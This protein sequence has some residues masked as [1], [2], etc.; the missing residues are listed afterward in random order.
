MERI[1]ESFSGLDREAYDYANQALEQ[2]E[3]VVLSA[4]GSLEGA[5]GYLLTLISSGVTI[6]DSIEA[7][8]RARCETDS[9]ALIYAGPTSKATVDDFCSGDTGSASTSAV[10]FADPSGDWNITINFT[11]DIM[12]TAAPAVIE[13]DDAYNNEWV[14]IVFDG[15]P[16]DPYAWDLVPV[17]ITATGGSIKEMR[18]YSAS[19][20]WDPASR[21]PL[22]TI[23]TPGATV[24]SLNATRYYWLYI[25]TEDPTLPYAYTMQIFRLYGE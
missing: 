7:A 9:K 5:L 6:D 24:F 12:T 13:D 21:N 8:E 4:G 11:Q 22:Y 16:A 3:R 19:N 25:Y 2:L 1:H 20:N 15:Y 10:S 14:R 17:T 18:I 23:L